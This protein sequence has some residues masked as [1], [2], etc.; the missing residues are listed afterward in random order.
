MVPGGR[1]ATATESALAFRLPIG[2]AID[3]IPFLCPDVEFDEWKDQVLF[4]P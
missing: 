2:R 3:E 4:L 1:S